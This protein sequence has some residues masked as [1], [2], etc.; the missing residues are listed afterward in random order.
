MFAFIFAGTGRIIPYKW[1]GNLYFFIS[2]KGGLEYGMMSA[3]WMK[4]ARVITAVFNDVKVKFVLDVPKANGIQPEIISEKLGKII[5][6]L[7]VQ[8][9]VSK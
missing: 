5:V 8:T 3:R 1:G 4:R 6:S 7:T 2:K 9:L